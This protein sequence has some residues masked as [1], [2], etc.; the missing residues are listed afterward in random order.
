MRSESL[1]ATIFFTSGV[2]LMPVSSGGL[3]SI[4]SLLSEFCFL[5]PESSK[6]KHVYG[7]KI[8]AIMNDIV[9][10]FLKYE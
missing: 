3:Y 9:L 1:L 8:K 6:Y 2:A 5:S 4:L 10:D 7:Y